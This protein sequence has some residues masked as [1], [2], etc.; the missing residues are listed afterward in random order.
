MLQDTEKNNH[1]LI[2]VPVINFVGWKQ[3]TVLL[4]GKVAQEKDFLN[5]KK[6]LK[7]LNI[8]Y[9][10]VGN[11]EIQ[12]PATWEYVYLEDITATVREPR[13]GKQDDQW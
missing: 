9:R 10:T 6:T 1:R 7:I 5:Q 3:F 8:Q 13:A 2:V 12:K 4:T 11:R